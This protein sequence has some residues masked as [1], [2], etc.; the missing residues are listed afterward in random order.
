MGIDPSNFDQ[1]EEDEDE[2][3]SMDLTQTAPDAIPE[4]DNDD[5]IDTSLKHS[6]C[7]S[8]VDDVDVNLVKPEADDKDIKTPTID[9]DAAQV[10]E[11]KTNENEMKLDAE[12][13][14]SS[15]HDDNQA[16]N[17]PPFPLSA[18]IISADLSPRDQRRINARIQRE[19]QREK[20]RIQK[21]ADKQQR[22]EERK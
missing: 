12:N 7:D 1:T 17:S 6:E 19:E 10:D 15:P 3:E 4:N 14:A 22:M 13:I 8:N 2:D 21:L 9:V 20:E 16:N 18:N 5:E 11:K